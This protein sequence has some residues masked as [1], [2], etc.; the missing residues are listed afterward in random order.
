MRVVQHKLPKA[1]EKAAAK[2]TEEEVLWYFY[3]RSYSIIRNVRDFSV[4]FQDSLRGKIS[5]IPM[6]IQYIFYL[7]KISGY[8][9]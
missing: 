7:F 9:K 4:P 2:P 1:E 6:S 8:N 3:Q 5:Y